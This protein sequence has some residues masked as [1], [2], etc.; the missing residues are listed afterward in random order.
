M[1]SKRKKSGDNASASASESDDEDRQLTENEYIV[2]CIL[3][4]E[5]RDGETK[6]LIKWYVYHAVGL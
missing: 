4:E 2:D 3:Y 1:A 6:Y 5:V